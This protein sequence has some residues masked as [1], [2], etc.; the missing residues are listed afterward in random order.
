MIPN[1]LLDGLD[2]EAATELFETAEAVYVL[3][4]SAVGVVVG[5]VVAFFGRTIYKVVMFVAGFVLGAVLGAGL[6][7]FAG[8]ELGALAG[9]LVVGVAAGAIA[10]WLAFVIP[11]IVGFVL[12]FGPAYLWIQPEGWEAAIPWL[13]GCVGAGL[14]RGFFDV[15]LIV[16]SAVSGASMAAMSAYGLLGVYLGGYTA[17]ALVAAVVFLLVAATGAIYQFR[18]MWRS[19]VG[20]GN[21]T[22][23]P[24]ATVAALP[25]APA[26]PAVPDGAWSLVGAEGPNVGETICIGRELIV[27]RDGDLGLR[28]EDPAVSRRHAMIDTLGDGG[29]RVTDLGSTNG[30]WV[31][32]ARLAGSVELREGDRLRFHRTG[33]RVARQ[34]R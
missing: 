23:K 4:A 9:G 30:T 2:L 12:V 22:S 34:S 19:E 29:L 5:L 26:A 16:G 24:G 8:G 11:A 28:L 10:V 13:L 20:E 25:E 3:G 27:G 14:A 18:V 32:D 7:V 15:L 1:D 21:A 33:F 17:A 6:G 31:N